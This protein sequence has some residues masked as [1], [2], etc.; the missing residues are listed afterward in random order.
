MKISISNQASQTPIT[1]MT[2]MFTIQIMIMVQNQTD[3]QI[4]FTNSKNKI[5]VKSR[6]SH[7]IILIDQEAQ[8]I[9][10]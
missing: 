1:K 8:S 4:N 9:C 7:Q 3:R 10:Y 5:K 6:M 2:M